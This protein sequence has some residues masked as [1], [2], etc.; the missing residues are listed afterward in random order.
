M[1]FAVFSFLPLLCRGF[2]SDFFT[3]IDSV[4]LSSGTQHTCAIEYRE[5]AEIGGHAKC[6]GLDTHGQSSDKQGPFVQVSSGLLVSCGILLDESVKCWGIHEQTIPGKFSQVSAG[7]A[8]ACALTNDGKIKCWGSNS[9]GEATPPT[10]NDFVQVSS[11][12]VL[13]QFIIFL[14]LAIST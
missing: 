13:S 7:Y 12:Q 8:H 11:G 9:Y 10:T 4:S 14:I 1:K 5:D 2:T 3:P 6:W